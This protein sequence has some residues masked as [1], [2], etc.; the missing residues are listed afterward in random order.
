ML[1]EKQKTAT[2]GEKL[3]ELYESENH[4]QNQP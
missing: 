1:T 3:T 2:L 4:G